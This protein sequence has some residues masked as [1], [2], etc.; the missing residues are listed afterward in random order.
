MT[1]KQKILNRRKLTT[2]IAAGAA[3]IVLAVGGYAIADASS[4]NG[5]SASANTANA[6]KVIPFQPG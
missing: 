5:A 6:A 1:L 3:A 4:S 2:S